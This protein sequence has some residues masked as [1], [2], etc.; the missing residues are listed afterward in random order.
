M[1][2]ERQLGQCGDFTLEAMTFAK[3][4]RMIKGTKGLAKG[5]GR[6]WLGL[7]L[8]PPKWAEFSINVPE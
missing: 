7:I 1:F 4:R 6:Y 3:P 8:N 2:V 5:S